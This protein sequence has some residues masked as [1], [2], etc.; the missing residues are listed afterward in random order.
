MRYQHNLNVTKS[1]R[2][3]VKKFVNLLEGTIKEDYVTEQIFLVGNH[4][5]DGHL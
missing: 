1:F 3:H 4:E 5:H 2:L